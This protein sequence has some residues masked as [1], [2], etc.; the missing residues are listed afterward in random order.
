MDKSLDR[1]AYRCLPL[2]I[3][4]THGWEL[5]CPYAVRAVWDG[6]SSPGAVQVVCLDGDARAAA[7]P[8]IVS[9]FGEGLL[10]FRPGYLFTTPDTHATYVSGP[11]NR[12]KDG[13]SALTGIVETAWLEFTFTMNWKFTRPHYPVWFDK[14][15]PFCIVFPIRL[16]EIE[17]VSP[18]VRDIASDPDL[19]RGYVEWRTA[20]VNF[21]AALRVRDE[22]AAAEGWQ[23]NYTHGVDFEGKRPLS[24]HRTRLKVNEFRCE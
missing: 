4:N 18:V 23:R 5:L 2:S 14:D 13:I 7:E 6:G 9:H 3:A 19:H 11:I 15:E 10:T 17:E 12:P 8:M 24:G 1:F 20:R 22:Q 16:A 21:N